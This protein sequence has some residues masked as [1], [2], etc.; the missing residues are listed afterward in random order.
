ETLDNLEKLVKARTEELEKAYNSLK[1]SEES[2]SEAQKMSHLGNWEWDIAS[3]K[4]YW[5]DETY[6]I[7][8]RDPK[9]LAPPYDEYLSYVHPDDRDLFY[10]ATKRPVSGKP[11]SIEYRII[12]PEGEER[13]IHMQSQVVF[14]ENNTP[15]RIKGTI[16]DITER[17][18]AERALVNLEIA[19]KK[20]I[21]HRIKNNLQVIS[22]L[23]DLQAENFR[24]RKCFKDSDV[25]NAFRESQDR[26][27]SI[28]LIHEELHEGGGNNTLYFSPYLEKL[29]ENL[30]QTYSIGNV[31][32][33][34]KMDLED[35]I[36]FDMDTA[37][38]LGIIV[39]EL[40]SNS[41]KHAFKGR[42]KG[43]IQIKL[44]RDKG[45]EEE[46]AGNEP[47]NGEKRITRKGAG[48]TL[49][50]SDDGTGIPEEINFENSDS[51]GLQLVN[52]LVDQLD[53][54]IELNIDRGT[55]FII[56]INLQ[57]G[58]EKPPAGRTESEIPDTSI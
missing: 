30:F 51:L 4:A 44:H 41:L 50:V 16:Q 31:D 6:R 18:K 48:Y 33:S 53:G 49:I 37:V 27:M 19:R 43:K 10:S 12:L 28:A 8:R 9:K 58:S 5:S 20:E 25:F 17:K 39:N 35:S 2:L 14:D 1:E 24:A 7:F 38:P 26:I 3:N 34:L 21:H 54:E 23:L 15:V 40:I 22:S 57:Q 32:I 47:D 46:K 11:Y 29:V 52:I 36:F 56:R 42:S 45:A 13:V 55:E